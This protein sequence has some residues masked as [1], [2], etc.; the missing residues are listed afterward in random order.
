MLKIEQGR[1]D[2]SS[3]FSQLADR[4]M[5]KKVRLGM[6]S[7]SMSTKPAFGS[8]I[9]KGFGG[10][11]NKHKYNRTEFATNKFKN[12]NEV[13]RQ[14][15]NGTCSYGKSCRKL[16]YCLKCYYQG[17]TESHKITS[18]DSSTISKSADQR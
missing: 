6:R 2:W 4:W 15:N 8:N 14:W 17:K 10:T 18:H 11:Y 9:G 7:R 3:D 13:C 5:D 16:H 12:A 1:L